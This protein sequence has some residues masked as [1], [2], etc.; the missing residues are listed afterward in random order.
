M[1]ARAR[2]ITWR[3][4]FNDSFSTETLK[5]HFHFSFS[6][7]D[8]NK[9]SNVSVISSSSGSPFLVRIYPNSDPP[10][11][12]R[13]H[14]SS[15]ISRFTQPVNIDISTASHIAAGYIV[16]SFFSLITHHGCGI[17][18]QR[19][20]SCGANALCLSDRSMPLTLYAPAPVLAGQV[21]TLSLLHFDNDHVRND[22]R[23]VVLWPWV[24][25]LYYRFPT[26]HVAFPYQHKP[27]RTISYCFC[28]MLN[29][30]VKMV[31]RDCFIQ[32]PGN[33][34]R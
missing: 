29:V 7:G 34:A 30:H 19:A 13:S 6:A 5:P 20:K 1:A 12:T 16:P 2:S 22:K 3:Y 33:F 18:N 23:R 11:F 4:S 17:F 21:A 25:G 28:A 10:I 31:P 15:D 26:Q 32:S 8:R 24:S 14:V 9:F 27:D